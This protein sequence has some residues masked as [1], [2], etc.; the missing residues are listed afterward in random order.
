MLAYTLRQSLFNKGYANLQQINKCHWV[1]PVTQYF[2]K[3]VMLENKKIS[4]NLRKQL[5]KMV[6]RQK[7]AFLKI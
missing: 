7:Y 6:Y 5:N 2:L 1:I 3:S 4:Y